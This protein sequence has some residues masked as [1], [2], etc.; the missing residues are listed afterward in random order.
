MLLCESLAALAVD[1]FVRPVALV[2][3]EDLGHIGIRV[4]VYLLEPIRDVVES[5]LVRAVIHENDA[6]GAL[7]VC[8][9]DGPEAFLAGGVPHLQLDPLVLHVHLLDFEVD[10]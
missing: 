6:H 7:I 3:H 4:L 2:R 10:A 8:L 9:G 1:D 5:G